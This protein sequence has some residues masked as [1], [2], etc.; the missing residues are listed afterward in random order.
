TG[1]EKTLFGVWKRMAVGHIVSN[2]TS[3]WD[4]LAIAQHHG[5]ATR[6]LDWTTNPLNAAYF[7]VR[8]PRKKRAASAHGPAVI[9]AARFVEPFKPSAETLLEEP[10]KSDSVAI[11]RPRYV[12][13]RIV[14]QEGLF[15]VHGPPETPLESREGIVDL[16]QIVIAEP[17][18]TNLLAELARYG[19][20]H[21]S[22]FPDLD[23]LSSYLNWTVESGKSS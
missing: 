21:A 14:R 2:I 16:E 20:N 1:H 13:P 4:W 5:L 12:V 17:Y 8:E 15:T 11:F 7:A 3:D 19:V 18:R 23:G 6:L 22:L 10:L 9:H